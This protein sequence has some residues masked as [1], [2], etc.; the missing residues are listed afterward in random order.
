MKK[1]FW[2]KFMSL[3]HSRE[4]RGNNRNVQWVRPKR[5]SRQQS[6]CQDFFKAFSST[7]QVKLL[8]LLLSQLY[9]S[10]EEPT[11]NW[12]TSS[13]LN[14]WVRKRVENLQE[15]SRS[16]RYHHRPFKADTTSQRTIF[17]FELLFVRQPRFLLDIAFTMKIALLSLLLSYVT[18]FQ[19]APGTSRITN[20]AL[21][22]TMDRRQ[23]AT[24]SL[25]TLTTGLAAPQVA[26]AF[27]R[28]E[29]YVPKFDDLKL[30]YGLVR[31]VIQRL[32]PIWLD[33]SFC[34]CL[35]FRKIYAIAKCCEI[36]PLGPFFSDF[37]ILFSTTSCREHLWI[38]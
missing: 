20:T 9:C 4:C 18:S 25:L 16:K 19:I 38:I 10:R 1:T 29:N 13:R 2:S 23:F 30:I 34:S 14:L 32:R 21:Q 35:P 36:T 28:G 37:L 7:V 27:A 5:W 26:S 3:N 6:G 15:P 8:A 11:V 33:F 12:L 31:V 24:Q 17:F 22:A